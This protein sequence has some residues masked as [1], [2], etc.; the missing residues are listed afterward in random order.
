MISGERVLRAL[1]VLAVALGVLSAG[2][3]PASDSGRPSEREGFR[4]MAFNIHHAAD[5]AG[6]L[7]VERTARVI[8]DSGADVVALQEV[9]RGVERSERRDILAELSELTGMPYRAFGKNLDFQGGG[10][11]N[12][13]LSRFPLADVENFLLDQHA[14]HEQRGVL[15]A[16]LD[17]EGRRLTIL[18][19]H[20]DHQSETERL[21]ALEQ[22]EELTEGGS[23]MIMAGDLNDVP[24]SEV[25]RRATS[26]LSD[27]WQTAGDGDGF[28]FPSDA[29]ERRIDYVFHSEHLVPVAASVPETEASDHRPVLVHF[30][31][32]D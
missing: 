2:C 28:T 3:A 13:L 20:L 1:A 18:V 5:A 11:G 6:V 25:Y 16:R 21:Y 12:A 24:A 22:I 32:N 23:P 17:V 19:V 15:R 26:W 31:F 9:D 4:M 29:P 10:Y 7:D 30:V 8:R 14:P 27:A